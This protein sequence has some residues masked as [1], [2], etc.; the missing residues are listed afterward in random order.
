MP[1]K[2]SNGTGTENKPP[3]SASERGLDALN[4]M[5]SANGGGNG[6]ENSG[7]VG[8][9]FLLPPDFDEMK[10]KELVA[11]AVGQGIAVPET[12]KS[13]ESVRQ[14]I[15]DAMDDRQNAASAA[16]EIDLDQLDEAGL[17]DL[18][19][20]MQITIP[21]DAALDYIKQLIQEA[22]G[23]DDDD[24]DDLD[25]SDASA[26][27]SPSAVPLA[28][29]KASPA[30]PHVLVFARTMVLSITG[31][32]VKAGQAV[33]SVAGI[34]DAWIREARTCGHIVEGP[35]TA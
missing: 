17:R 24:D 2:N 26:E 25:H 8:G 30:T 29:A 13:K 32:Q 1:R 16:A 28:P 5:D 15:R 6:A 19:E 34:D 20:K 10:F 7:E 21:D 22:A 11:F 27:T 33:A 18:A 4:R 31:E 9:P 35:V 12:A 14:L 3:K 23:Q